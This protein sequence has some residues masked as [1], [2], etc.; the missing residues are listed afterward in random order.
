MKGVAM[1][2]D[3]DLIAKL[4]IAGIGLV[5]A[6]KALYELSIARHSKLREAYKFSQ[7]FLNDVAA[8]NGI[9][10]FLKEKGYQAL[11][12]DATISGAEVEYLLSLTRPDRALGDYVMG[13][14]YL[15]HL[16][17]SGNLQIK[18]K[19]RYAVPWKLRWLRRLYIA[20]YGCFTFAAFSPWIFSSYLR[21]SPQNSLI[22]LLIGL[23]TVFPYGVLFLRSATKI[24]RAQ[25]LV[26]NQNRHTQRIVVSTVWG[27]RKA[28]E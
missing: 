6:A 4:L 9:H 26:A 24:Q 10:P 15:E 12:G 8:D 5:G 2:L 25:H 17:A 18:F 14:Q 11:A 7:A 27:R 19:K 22:A 21:L 28:D 1:Q 23:V 13:R 16:P 20:L 3:Y